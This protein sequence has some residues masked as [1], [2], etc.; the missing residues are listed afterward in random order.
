MEGNVDHLLLFI[1]L[2]LY[3]AT[4]VWIFNHTRSIKHSLQI[5]KKK[6]HYIKREGVSEKATQIL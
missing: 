5:I 2:N 1:N 3:L 4:I 6:S